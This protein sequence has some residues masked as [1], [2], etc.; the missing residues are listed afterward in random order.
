MKSFLIIILALSISL[1]NSKNLKGFGY[2]VYGGDMDD[3]ELKLLSKQGTTDIFLNYLA[4]KTHG[5]NEII[6]WIMKANKLNIRIH[7]WM[8]VFYNGIWI[9]PEEIDINS[10]VQEAKK[11][12]SIQGVSGIHF[13]YLRY[14]GTAYQYSHGVEK[15][16]LFIKVAVA[17]IHSINSQ[18]IVSASLMPETSRG[19]YLYGQNYEVFSTYFDVVLPMIFKGNN[20]QQTAWI[21]KITEWFVQNSK[22]ASVWA[23]IQSYRSDND[24]TPLSESALTID[25]KSALSAK[26]DGIILFRYGVSELLDFKSLE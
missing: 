15:I 24:Y 18:C 22:G 26:P 14:P 12:A 6:S 20:K 17:G 2:W 25:I 5:E 16:N 7:V 13:D 10:I 21:Q 9:N 4:F 19:E 8:Q 11:Y 3:L 1:N 23:G